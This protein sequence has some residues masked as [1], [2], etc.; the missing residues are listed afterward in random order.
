LFDDSGNNN[1]G[2]LTNMDPGDWVPSGGKL[3][4][5]F[6]GSNDYV[7]LRG[8]YSSLTDFT[9][10][11]WINIAVYPSTV[12]GI[13]SGSNAGGGF[14]LQARSGQILVTD[15]WTYEHRSSTGPAVNTWTHVA[16]QYPK[17]RGQF[18]FNGVRQT[19][20]F[21]ETAITTSLSF[22]AAENRIFRTNTFGNT[23]GYLQGQLD[24]IR[25]YNRALTPSEIQLLY[26]GG[27]GA[28]YQLKERGRKK[29]YVPGYRITAP[30]RIQTGSARTIDGTDTESLRRGLVG[31]WCPSLGA[32]GFR[33]IDRSGYGNHGVLIGMDPGTDWV[34][35]GGKLALDFDG[36][37][38]YCDISDKPWLN[39]TKQITVC[40]WYNSRSVPGSF[41]PF[42]YCLLG[43]SS[44]V[45]AQPY[46]AFDIRG[47][48]V[49]TIECA[50]A[51]GSSSK[52]ISLGTITTNRWT[53]VAATYSGS[54]LSGYRDDAL[55]Q[56]A[57]YTGDIGTTTQ[58]LRLG[59]NPG[60]PSRWYNGQLDDIRIYNRALTPSEIRLLYTGG[61]G[62][63]L[64]PEVKPKRARI[65][66]WDNQDKISV[67]ARVLTNTDSLKRGLVGHW[68]PS[69]SGP[70]GN[71][72]MD[73]SGQNNHGVLTNMDY[74][75]DYV[76]SAEKGGRMA[77][78]FDG[79][80]DY[81]TSVA[82]ASL[83]G[84]RSPITMSLWTYQRLNTRNM[85]PLGIEP[86]A[87]GT[88]S[89]TITAVQLTGVY[90]IWTDSRTTNLTVSASEHPPLFA[91]NHVAVS[92][93]G[94]VLMYYLNGKFIKAMSY[95]QP[96]GVPSIVL[97]G[98]RLYLGTAYYDG[99]LDDI[100]IYNRALTPQ[101][102]RLLA[103]SR[104]PE[105]A[106]PQRTRT[107]FYS[108]GLIS[109]LRRRSYNSILGSGVLS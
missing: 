8:A 37:N 59:D 90:Y 78:D 109:Y 58:P 2:V 84:G 108:S 85:S 11:C 24:D 12:G 13:Y 67:P 19:M 35:S 46:P 40:C 44:S 88:N 73:L 39:P 38:D 62:V 87:I 47:S 55:I 99:Q 83:P 3:A 48:S 71:R 9:F 10:S 26:T 30:S 66:A 61:R 93:D 64:A 92:W 33:L 36:V 75:T 23:T 52:Q 101:E 56:S 7:A 53:F 106:T 32:S 41:A 97:I 50:I 102:I 14:G 81:I 98:S 79:S 28:A 49:T 20:A 31:A 107:V 82:P 43:K 69:V 25:I 74:Q 22:N 104:M 57:A 65:V 70:Q 100:R 105:T 1:H 42:N 16:I 91:W 80:N 17:N 60:F 18:F 94:N 6:D 21:G 34:T 51:I 63:G 4:L 95:T 45:N 89:F 5:D 96:I 27:R 103:Q 15:N 76:P 72:L 77:L 68:S 86:A 54:V 29:A